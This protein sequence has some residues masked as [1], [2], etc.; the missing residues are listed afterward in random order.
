MLTVRKG[1]CAAPQRRMQSMLT[2]RKGDCAAPQGRKQNIV[3]VSRQVIRE[4]QVMKKTWNPGRCQEQARIPVWRQGEG[5]SLSPVHLQDHKK[6]PVIQVWKQKECRRFPVG[7]ECCDQGRSVYP[8][9]RL[10]KRAQSSKILSWNPNINR[11]TGKIF[12]RKPRSI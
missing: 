2:V 3:P 5:K 6:S 1:D 10:Y 7:Q 9:R 12:V 4:R 8:V 11:K